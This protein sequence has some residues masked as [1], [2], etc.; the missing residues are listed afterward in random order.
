MRMSNEPPNENNPLNP[1]DISVYSSIKGNAVY[2][3]W[4][5][6]PSSGS[7]YANPLQ[8]VVIH[9]S[10]PIIEGEMPNRHITYSIKV[11]LERETRY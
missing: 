11:E 4:D 6:T 2:P 1:R 3:F 5:A 7:F 9:V 10:D 8:N